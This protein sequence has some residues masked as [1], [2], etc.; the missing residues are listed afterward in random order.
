VWAAAARDGDAFLRLAWGKAQKFLMIPEI[1]RAVCAVEAALFSGLIWAEPGDPRP[2]DSAQFVLSGEEAS[3]LIEAAGVQFGCLRE[4]HSCVGGACIR[5]R[6]LSRRFRD[7]L[8]APRPSGGA[9]E[10]AQP[11]V[12]S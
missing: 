8:E 6:P 12:A 5:R 11:A 3:L 9:P 10:N 7:K 4:D 2:G 1:W